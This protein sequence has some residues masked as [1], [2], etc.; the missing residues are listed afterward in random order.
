[1]GQELRGD[2]RVV[3]SSG[4]FLQRTDMNVER[5]CKF[6]YLS[7]T[8]RPVSENRILCGGPRVLEV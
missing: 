3:V 7:H 4:I 1:M 2:R 6:L 8:K 5:I